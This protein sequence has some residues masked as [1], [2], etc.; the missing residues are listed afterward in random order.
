M[1][2]KVKKYK[3]RILC[4]LCGNKKPYKNGICKDCYEYE[5]GNREQWKKK[6]LAESGMENF[7]DDLEG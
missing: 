1:V 6:M 4:K 3:R 5:Y 7:M 2:I